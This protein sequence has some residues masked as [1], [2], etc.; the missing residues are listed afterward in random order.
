MKNLNK[1]LPPENA[2]KWQIGDKL[3][4]INDLGLPFLKIGAL[5]CV[6]DLLHINCGP[7]AIDRMVGLIGSPKGEYYVETAFRS[8]GF[9]RGWHAK[10][11]N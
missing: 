6:E 2:T 3:V 8:I 11:H 10:I 4:C 1:P 5:Y 9:M 7:T